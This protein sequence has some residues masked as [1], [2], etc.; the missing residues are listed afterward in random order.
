MKVAILGATGLI[1][2]QFIRL[3]ANH[4][5]FE[6]AHLYASK[7]SENKKVHEFWELPYF[8]VPVSASDMV[9]EDINKMAE[10]CDIVF[11]GLPTKVALKFE[12]RLRR[13]GIG[14]FSN[15]SAH[16]MDQDV[17]IL[18]PEINGTHIGLVDTQ[19]DKLET[20][21]FIICNSNC[22][23]AGSAVYLAELSKLIDLEQVVISTYQALSG[24]GIG[25]VASLNSTNNVV[26]YISNEEPK[27]IEESLKMIGSF[28]A[29]HIQPYKA[30][31]V[32]NAARVNVI[33]GHLEAISIFTDRMVDMDELHPL[34][35][36]RSPLN[37]DDYHIAP[38]THL[39]FL[40]QPNR[41]QPSRD[42]FAG[43]PATARGMTVSF[44]RL[45]VWE[46]SITSYILVHNTIRGG[47]GGSVLNAEYALN[48]GIL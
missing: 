37:L 27:I 28:E 8:D 15:A 36:V 1:G 34:K 38:K 19:R 25:G 32:A 46:N 41:P 33:D 14:V 13:N 48:E 43:E 10:D 31:V 21:G 22:S 35:K 7:Q 20:D 2:Q 47:A 17:P 5:K 26:P 12:D 29:D 40:D 6:L 45:R 30:D 42:A 44:G 4:P 3:L 11:S 23:A 24:A 9:V 16:R 18:I 39:Q